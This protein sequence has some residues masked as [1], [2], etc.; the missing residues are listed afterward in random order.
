MGGRARLPFVAIGC[1]LLVVAVAAVLTR[2]A[3]VRTGTND[4]LATTALGGTVGRLAVCQDA[5]LIPPGTGAVRVWL[6]TT[7]RPGPALAVTA[8]NGR[9]TIGR[10]R[11]AA[12][13]SGETATIPLRPVTRAPRPARVCVTVGAA[14]SV[15]IAGEASGD[16]NAGPPATA[17][18]SALRGRLRIEYLTPE[19]QSWW[20][21]IGAVA[22]RMGF[23]RAPGGGLVAYAAALLMLAAAS[24]ALWQLVREQR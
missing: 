1:V 22:R 24:L 17:S 6:R 19:R 12:G 5:E 18:G 13:W 15:T 14:S 4:V 16:P 20:S 2:A 21:Q 23:G 11:L 9:T 3:P 10:G 8:A 7:G